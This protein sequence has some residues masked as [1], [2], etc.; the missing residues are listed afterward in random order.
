MSTVDTLEDAVARERELHRKGH[1]RRRLWVVA[2]SAHAAETWFKSSPLAGLFRPTEIVQ[3]ADLYLLY[4]KCGEP[5]IF[6]SG[7]AAQ[8]WHAGLLDQER[9]GRIVPLLG[10]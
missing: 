8:E 4:G 10:G 9:A 7:T 6:V 2:D 3:R 5:Y 1:T